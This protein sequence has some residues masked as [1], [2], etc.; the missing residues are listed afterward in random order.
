MQ[1]SKVTDRLNQGPMCG[2]EGS[3]KEGQAPN[4]NRKKRDIAPM[5]LRRPP[6]PLHEEYCDIALR[7]QT[8]SK[9]VMKA[10]S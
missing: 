7:P 2:I 1:K 10:L 8:R 3:R 9:Y 6:P 4:D 5:K